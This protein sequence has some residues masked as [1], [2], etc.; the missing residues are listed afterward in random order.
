MSRAWLRHALQVL[1]LGFVGWYIAQHWT[2]Y[3][4]VVH[5]AHPDWSTIAQSCVLVLISYLVLIVTWQQTV[6]AWGER[7]A[8]A[9]AAR[10]WFISNLGKYVPGKVWAI[11]AMG[12]LAQEAGIS[13]VA[14]IGSSLV[15]QLVNLATGFGVFAV[16]GAHVMQL[17]GGTS[18]ALALLG[19]VLLLAPWLVPAGVRLVNRVSPR[20]FA[21]PHLPARAIWWAGAGTA[22]AWTLYGVAFQWFASGISGGATS[23]TT[24]DWVAIFIGPYLLGFLAIFSPGGL[25]VRELAMAEAL[26]RT[27]MATGALSAL[28]VAASRLWLTVLELVPGVLF[29]ILRPASRRVTSSDS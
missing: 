21:V 1:L 7:L 4:E 8:F 20:Q 14:A 27:G 11:A 17:P 22:L 10:I 6:V 18:V 2:E 3:A 12:T 26:Q 25:G 9:D 15:V 23:G 29:L 5:T 16:A 24:G 19:A 28:L 13:P